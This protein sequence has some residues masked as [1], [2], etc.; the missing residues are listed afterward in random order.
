MLQHLKLLRCVQSLLSYHWGPNPLNVL[1]LIFRSLMKVPTICFATFSSTAC[2]MVLLGVLLLPR[3]N[4]NLR[5]QFLMPLLHSRPFSHLFSTIGLTG[6][7][8]AK[9]RKQKVVFSVGSAPK[10]YNEDTTQAAVSCQ[11]LSEV[12]G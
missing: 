12:A 5:P 7:P 10:L 8:L 4:R 9:S 2:L 11:Q 6:A 3:C 1:T